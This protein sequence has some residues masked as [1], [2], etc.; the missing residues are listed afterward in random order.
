MAALFHILLFLAIYFQVSSSTSDTLNKGSTLSVEKPDDV[1]TSLDG[2]FTAGFHQVGNN[3]FCFAIWFTE[4]S[5]HYKNRTI[6]WMAN[7]V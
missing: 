7:V 2:V 1:L 4:K 3:S 5:D 6:V